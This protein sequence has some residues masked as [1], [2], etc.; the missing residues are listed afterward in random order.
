MKYKSNTMNLET[1]DK[2]LRLVEVDLKNIFS[3]RKSKNEEDTIYKKI[4]RGP[5]ISLFEKRKRRERF[6][7]KPQE[8]AYFLKSWMSISR[9]IVEKHTAVREQLKLK[10]ILRELFLRLS[11]EWPLPIIEIIFDGE[12]YDKDRRFLNKREQFLFCLC[13]RAIIEHLKRPRLGMKLK[14]F[15]YNKYRKIAAEEAEI[16]LGSAVGKEHAQ[17]LGKTLMIDKSR[18]ERGRRAYILEKEKFEKWEGLKEDYEQGWIGAKIPSLGLR[19]RKYWSRLENFSAKPEKWVWTCQCDDL[20][21]KG[22]KYILCLHVSALMWRLMEAG[23]LDSS[24]FNEL[25]PVKK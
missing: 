3:R 9:D 11:N 17:R 7:K 18:I 19:D 1:L 23:R 12:E 14:K 5:V 21:A 6:G 16:E 8:A 13:A 24:I 10:A 22:S 20:S 4:V 15:L 25:K 2:E